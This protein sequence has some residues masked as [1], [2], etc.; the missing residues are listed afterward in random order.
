MTNLV[1]VKQKE[2]RVSADNTSD[3]EDLVDD[4]QIMQVVK[5][6]RTQFPS[7]CYFDTYYGS[8]FYHERYTAYVDRI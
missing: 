3:D 7:L 8:F 4:S 6:A 1:Y 5:K 2:N